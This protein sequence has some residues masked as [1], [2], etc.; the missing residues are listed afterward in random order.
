MQD[1][2]TERFR[3]GLDGALLLLTPL[4]LPRAI[5][6]FADLRVAVGFVLFSVEVMEAFRLAAAS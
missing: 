3:K 2:R 5:T 4:P 6:A 1:S